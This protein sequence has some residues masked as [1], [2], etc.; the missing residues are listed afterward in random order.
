L[1]NDAERGRR[2]CYKD[3]PSRQ[4]AMAVSAARGNA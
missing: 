3:R 1:G 4:T 2:L